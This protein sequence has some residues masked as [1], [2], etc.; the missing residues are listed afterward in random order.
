VKSEKLLIILVLLFFSTASTGLAQSLQ[1]NGYARSYMGVLIGADKN[2]SIMQNYIDLSLEHKS[3]NVSLK[4]NPYVYKN[5]NEDMYADLRQLYMDIYFDSFDIRVGKQQIIWG[6]A[7]GVFITDIVSPKDLR[8]FLLPDF[9]E[10]RMGI[11]SIKL[12]YYLA[13][14]TFEMVWAPVFTPTNE[15]EDGSIWRISPT[16]PA[17]VTFDNSKKEVKANLE[18]SEVFAKYSYLSSLID[19]EIMGGYMWDDSPA[20]HMDPTIDSTSNKITAVTVAPEYHRLSLAGGSLSTSLGGYVLRGEGGYF[21]GKYFETD[22]LNSGGV[23]I[24]DYI[25][26][27]LG[28]DCSF[29][30]INL[31]AQFIQQLILEYDSRIT[32]DEYENMV[33]FLAVK[34]Y[35][36]ETLRLEFFAYIGLNNED[37]LLRPRIVYDVSDEMDLQLG[38]NIFTGDKGN[39]GQYNENDM[40]YMKLKYSF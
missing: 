28:I 9:S 16:L 20:L 25:N 17:P 31:S 15:P 30:D 8:E 37:A 4:I 35:F 1:L 2:Y 14:S 26:Y 23:I 12:D 22:D 13:D 24:K 39:F 18:N 38:A 7:E 27:V 34:D 29:M 19:F 40:A 36:R 21:S 5:T 32:S 11:T 3:N 6:K 10:I 33:T